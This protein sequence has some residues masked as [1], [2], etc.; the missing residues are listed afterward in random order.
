MR[1]KYAAL[2]ALSLSSSCAGG[3]P[4]ILGET[5]PTPVTNI[6]ND[7]GVCAFRHALRTRSTV[8]R[9]G[10]YITAP[11]GKVRLGIYGDSG[12]KPSTLLA[13]TGDLIVPKCV[14]WLTAD[15][16]QPVELAPGDYW[17]AQTA[18]APANGTAN[19]AAG[20][21]FTWA[22]S[23][24]GLPVTFPS[25]AR[26]T[27]SGTHWSMVM[28][29]VLAG[30]EALPPIPPTCPSPRVEPTALPAAGPDIMH[31]GWADIAEPEQTFASEQ[32][33]DSSNDGL[34]W[35]Q[36]TS[37]P[38][39]GTV[40][41][42]SIYVNQ[43]LGGGQVSMDLYTDAGD[44]PGDLVAATSAGDVPISG[45]MT[46]PMTSPA[47][48]ATGDYWLVYR[49]TGFGISIRKSSG[50]THY[51]WV[52]YP[53]SLSPPATFPPLSKARHA[54]ANRPQGYTQAVVAT[55]DTR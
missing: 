30:S 4:V 12:G 35:A 25:T 1:T 28:H 40:T 18:S 37:V 5:R 54:S 51:V 8:R 11:Y 34:L 19:A 33:Y 22:A 36:K 2:F 45:W 29:A 49:Y 3:N 17:L 44:M 16:V 26:K 9:L 53:F 55:L 42:M 50:N 46:L 21:R 6:E 15:V 41:S 24:Y 43:A 10:I 13:S 23:G 48:I 27:G 20:V 31:V 52:R 38:Q 7:G 47:R 32:G 39:D 14:G